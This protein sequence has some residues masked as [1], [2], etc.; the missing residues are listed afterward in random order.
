MDFAEKGVFRCMVCFEGFLGY[1]ERG[2]DYI[3][4]K[5]LKGSIKVRKIEVPDVPLKVKCNNL[6]IGHIAEGNTAILD[7]D[8]EVNPERDLLVI[9]KTN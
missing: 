8:C 1:V 5:C 9:F 4:L 3:Q 6:E 7:N 2:V